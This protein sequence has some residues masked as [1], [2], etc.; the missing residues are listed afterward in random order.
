MVANVNPKIITWARHR[1]GLSIEDLAGKMKRKPEEIRMWE[2]GSK[3]PSYTSLEA[4]AYRHLKITL[5]LFFFPDPPDIEDPKTKFRRLPDYEFARLSPDT[6][7]MMQLAQGYQESVASLMPRDKSVQRIFREIVPRKLTPR[8]LG[9]QAR[10]YIGLSMEQQFGFANAEAAFKGWR[11]ALEMAGIFTFKGSLKDR[12]ISGFSLLDEGFP[13]IFVNNSSAFTRQ[14]FTLAHELG[15]ILWQVYG[16][17]DI[18]DSYIKFMSAHDRSIEIRCNQF[19]AELLVPEEAFE[20]E[21]TKIKTINSKIISKLAEKYSVSREVILRRFLDNR[22]IT[23]EYYNRKSN[24]WTQDYLRSYKKSTGGNYYFTKLA[25]LGEGFT[26]I[27]FE[28]FHQGR[29]T[30]AELATHLNVKARH[31]DKLEQTM[32]WW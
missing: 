27:A 23:N 1:C 13:I 3:T 32:A 28:N 21:I 7:Q 26:R 6:I 12:F 5:A 20:E 17:T 4:L 19:A 8:D 30:K 29:L 9:R 10:Q 16:I 25:Y 18:D 11:H 15:H 24:E 22:L 2:D 31:L 14:T